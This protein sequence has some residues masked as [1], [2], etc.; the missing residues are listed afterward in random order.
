MDLWH[1]EP[2]CAPSDEEVESQLSYFGDHKILSE[3][4]DI[5]NGLK[6]VTFEYLEEHE[7]CYTDYTD[8]L[9]FQFENSYYAAGNGGPAS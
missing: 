8:Q 4:L 2:L 7:N 1:F 5:E 6:T 9:I 3:E